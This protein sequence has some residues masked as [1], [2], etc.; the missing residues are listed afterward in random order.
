MDLDVLLDTKTRNRTEEVA[1]DRVISGDS[2]SANRIDPEQMC[3]TSFGDY[4][5]GPPALPCLRDDALVVNDAAAP[6]PCLSPVKM[7]TR[8]VAGGLLFAGKV[9]SDEDHQL[10]IASL[11]LPDRGDEF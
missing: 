10:P 11:V 5:N 2:S 7:H 8:T 1:A 9:Y 4:F 6:K 3:L